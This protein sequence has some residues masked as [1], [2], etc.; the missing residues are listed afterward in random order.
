M[1]WSPFF[2]ITVLQMYYTEAYL[3]Q[4]L[5]VAEFMFGKDKWVLGTLFWIQVTDLYIWLSHPS[6][7]KK[8]E[9]TFISVNKS[10]LYQQIKN[11]FPY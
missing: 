9:I 8:K 4:L 11:L 1:V 3:L 6:P 10:S 2:N 5:N 7:Q